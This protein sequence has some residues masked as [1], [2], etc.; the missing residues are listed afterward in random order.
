MKAYLHTDIEG[1]AGWAFYAAP[2]HFYANWEHT[3]RMNRLLTAE[4]VAAAKA[5]EECGVTEIFVNDAHGP[6]YNIFFEDLPRSCKI[7]H[8]RP[9]HGPNWVPMLDE[10]IDF[11]IAIGQHA[12]AGTPMS[13]CNHSLWYLTDGEGQVHKLSETTMFA[14]LAAKYNVPLIM[15]SGDDKIAEEVTTRIPNSVAAVV[16]TALGLQ[17]ACTLTPAVACDL[18]AEKVKEAVQKRDQIQPLRFKGPFKL[19]LCDRD[20][21]LQ[22]LAEP[23]EGDE[24][25]EL[26]HRTCNAA[27]ANFGNQDV[28]DDRSFR[29][30]KNPAQG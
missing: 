5:L 29:W 16:K 23:Q 22:A 26:M 3:Q 30:P 18:I 12:M 15:V 6:S 25:F 13:V 2:G 7:I 14:A 21:A 24:I 17:N 9:G 8:G 11:A 1:V 28:V 20:P 4:V 19:N 27:W 10:S